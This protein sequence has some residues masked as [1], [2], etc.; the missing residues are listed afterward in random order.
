MKPGTKEWDTAA[1]QI[2]VEEAGGA[3]VKLDGSAYTYNRE[4]VIN[5]EPYEILNRIENLIR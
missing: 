5:E 2:I 4:N 1:G 3:V